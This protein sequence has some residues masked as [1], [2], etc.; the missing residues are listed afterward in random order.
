MAEEKLALRR[1][2]R[3][4]ADGMNE[5]Y[6]LDANTGKEITLSDLGKYKILDAQGASLDQLGLSPKAQES[7]SKVE[8]EQEVRKSGSGKT[9]RSGEYYEGVNVN[10][11]GLDPR[12]A[13][14]NFGYAPRDPILEAL[15]NT[16]N[17]I[18]PTQAAARLVNFARGVNNRYA[19]AQ[20]RK[21]LG[22]EAPKGKRLGD[23]QL[24]DIKIGDKTYPVG[25]EAEEQLKSDIPLKDD[26]AEFLGSTA[27]GMVAGPLGGMVGGVAAKE[28]VKDAAKVGRTNLTLEEARRRQSIAAD[29]AKPR[30]PADLG[31]SYAGQE[32][33]RRNVFKD[34]EIVDAEADQGETLARG[35]GL[36]DLSPSFRNGVRYSHAATRGPVETGLTPRSIE[37]MQTLSENTL[38]GINV[39]SAYRSPSV[40]AAVG[41]ASGSLHKTGQAF[42]VS[43][44]GMT[45]LEKR[46][47]VERAIMS[48]AMEIGSYPD[49]SIHVGTV[50][51]MTPAMYD[52]QY[53]D[54]APVDTGGVTAMFN[55]TRDPDVYAKAPDWFRHGVEVSRLAPTPTE[56]PQGFM[57]AD[58]VAT[59]AKVA[60]S[61]SARASVDLTRATTYSD[62][63]KRLMGATLA[64][65]IDP[66]YTDLSTPEGIAEARGIMS[67]MENR[68][69]KYGTMKDTLLAPAQYSTW[70]TDSAA[71]TAINNYKANPAMYDKIVNDFF[72]DPKSNTGFTH[73][74][75]ASLVS[76]EWGA[77]LQKTTDIGPHRFGMLGDY[78]NAFGTNF[79]SAPGQTASQPTQ[80]GAGTEAKAATKASFG[81][82][83]NLSASL[84]SFTSRG[85]ASAENANRATSQSSTARDSR[86]TT[87]SSGFG[88]SSASSSRSTG[89]GKGSYGSSGRSG[90]SSIGSGSGFSSAK[91][92]SEGK[93]SY[94][95]S[96][97][98][99]YSSVGSSKSSG[100]GSRSTADSSKPGGRV[101]RDEKGWK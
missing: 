14:N 62:M 66:R 69:G 32:G 81:T 77:K 61:A 70:N 59:D 85:M 10:D 78:Q 79:K 75:N 46:D 64:G 39:T 96:G 44:R 2:R 97:R 65:E 19:V 101:D 92:P 4:Q 68:V 84:D 28:L 90:Y 16:P 49:Q 12:S 100:F 38:G 27:G 91:S 3:K 29:Q 88:S 60:P 54:K 34:T 23:G 40:N 33:L 56:K 76:P 5:T 18:A 48:G 95:S 8:G 31:F 71:R 20:G 63:E 55:R 50:Q 6:Y 74:Y 52:P 30:G 87:K 41:G 94:G 7:A 35:M 21:V 93:G 80:V 24:G 11:P 36:G 98:S 1:V 73:Y 43:T 37:A 15:A 45:D 26:I 58:Q 72:A 83:N 51:R 13:A 17:P 67:T 53:A 82:S 57:Q 47:L 22:I 89:E 25:Y 9:D 99:G 42:D 86:D